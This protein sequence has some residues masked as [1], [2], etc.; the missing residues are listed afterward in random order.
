MFLADEGLNL[1]LI[2]VEMSSFT[3]LK[4]NNLIIMGNFKLGWPV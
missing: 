1:D 4:D 3:L 2:F